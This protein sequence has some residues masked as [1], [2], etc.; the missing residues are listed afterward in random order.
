MTLHP[1]GPGIRIQNR[2]KVRTLTLVAPPGTGA[3]GF[4][5]AKP[6]RA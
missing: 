6:E 2:L 4:A 5:I 3:G 1:F